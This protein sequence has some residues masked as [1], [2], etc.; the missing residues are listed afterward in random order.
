MLEEIYEGLEQKNGRV[1]LTGLRSLYLSMGLE[2][3][4]EELLLTI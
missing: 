4:D 3:S 2:P 1:G